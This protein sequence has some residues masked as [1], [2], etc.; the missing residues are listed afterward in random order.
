LCLPNDAPPLASALRRFRHH[1]SKL[2]FRFLRTFL[3]SFCAKTPAKSN[4]FMFYVRNVTPVAGL[5]FET[6]NRQF[7]LER[8]FWR[9]FSGEKLLPE[10][11]TCDVLGQ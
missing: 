11:I 7:F 1:H 9:D 4:I 3:K 2:D 8:I 6:K 10:N 5:I